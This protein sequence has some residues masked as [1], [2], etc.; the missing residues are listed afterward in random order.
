MIS[1]EEKEM[2]KLN[3]DTMSRDELAHHIVAYRDSLHGIEAR[4]AFIRRM[5]EKAK[6][7]GI[8]IDRSEV[9]TKSIKNN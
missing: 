3:F 4:R 6:S 9:Q 8:E 7:L 2:S 1:L 5:V